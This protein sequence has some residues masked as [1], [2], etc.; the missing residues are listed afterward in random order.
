MMI[1]ILLMIISSFTIL[2]ADSADFSNRQ[3]IVLDIKQVIQKEEEI[4]RSF[5]KYILTNYSL[6]ANITALYT[7]DYLGTSDDFTSSI[8]NFADNF[9]AFI[10]SGNSLSYT[11][12][13]TLKNDS[14]YSSLYEGDTF[15]KRTYYRNKRV[16]LVLEDVFAK[17]LYDI[18]RQKGS[19]LSICLSSFTPDVSCIYNNHIYIK[20]TYSAGKISTFLMSYHVDKFRTGP[21]IVTDNT[22][23]HLTENEFKS[24]PRG[25][26]IY[27]IKGA[28]YIKTNLGI[29]VLK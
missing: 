7:I 15:R 16:Y 4:A 24:I 23:L 22:T 14:G 6:P 10:L 12:K 20:P 26:L 13:D 25:A 2:L 21:I 3:K 9:K 19:G 5:E 1:K 18:I 29:E 11:M 8:S 28:K 27:D 17:H